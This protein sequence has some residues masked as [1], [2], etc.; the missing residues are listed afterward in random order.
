MNSLKYGMRQLRMNPGFA[1]TAILS[2]ALGIG[3]NTAFFTLVDQ[4]LLRLLPVDK[5]RERVQLRGEGGRAIVPARGTPS[6]GRFKTIPW[7]AIVDEPPPS[8]PIAVTAPRRAICC[9]SSQLVRPR[10]KELR[11]SATTRRRRPL[12][13]W[14]TAVRGCGRLRCER[15]NCSSAC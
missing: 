10:E 7:K 3:A 8:K 14:P 12:P 9:A 5:P 1:L 11:P 2:L 6:E 4:I 15:V 13:S